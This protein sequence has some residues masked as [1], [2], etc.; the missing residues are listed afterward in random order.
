MMPIVWLQL[1]LSPVRMFLMISLMMMTTWLEKDWVMIRWS[2]VSSDVHLASADVGAGAGLVTGHCSGHCD[3]HWELVMTGTCD[4]GHSS[5]THIVDTAG[6]GVLVSRLVTLVSRCVD[7]GGV[8]ELVLDV[9]HVL[10]HVTGDPDTGLV[11]TWAWYHWHHTRVT[12]LLLG[13]L[14]LQCWLHGS[15]SVGEVGE[16]GGVATMHRNRKVAGTWPVAGR[17]R[18]LVRHWQTWPGA[19]VGW[20]RRHDRGRG[21]GQRW[22]TIAVHQEE[23]ES[24]LLHAGSVGG[25]GRSVLELCVHHPGVGVS[26]GHSTRIRGSRHEASITIVIVT[27]QTKHCSTR[28]AV[29]RGQSPGDA[30]HRDQDDSNTCNQDKYFRKLFQWVVGN[31]LHQW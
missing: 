12:V 17:S 29:L 14:C 3:H 5:S 11:L 15:S 16:L 25:R 22:S 9:A 26:V 20:R 18:H 31:Y 24:V 19:P 27:S 13:L 7:G 21:R 30:R 10:V 23:S 8:L 4:H 2:E 1:L 6:A 28:G